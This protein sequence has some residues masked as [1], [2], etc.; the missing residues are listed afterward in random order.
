MSPCLRRRSGAKAGRSVNS[1]AMQCRGYNFL[2]EPLSA[3]DRVT[4]ANTRE[5][6]PERVENAAHRDFH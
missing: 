4:P 6:F 3:R 5:H 2:S 1:T